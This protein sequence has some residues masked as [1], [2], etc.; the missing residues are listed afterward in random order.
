MVTYCIIS[1]FFINTI[2]TFRD[3]FYE[4]TTD[5]SLRLYHGTLI[6]NVPSILAQGLTPTVGKFTQELY[7]KEAIPAVFASDSKGARAVYCA[8]SSQIQRKLNK[9]NYIPSSAD[10]SKH[11]ALLV[12][13]TN[14]GKFN[15]HISNQ[16]M[17][18]IEP[19]NYTSTETI[20]IDNVLKG[21][22]LLQWIK[23]HNADEGELR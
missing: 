12:I 4:N 6:D 5:N 19:G 8:L 14:A 16:N 1:S 22:D 9:G 11:G 13:H 2:M 7:K 10:I 17:G 3:F 23:D 15:K 18:S 21:N 20:T